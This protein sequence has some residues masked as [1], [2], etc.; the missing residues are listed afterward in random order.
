MA[1]KEFNKMIRLE[2]L[3]MGVKAL[4]YGLPIGTI[5]SFLLCKLL[6]RNVPIQIKFPIIQILVATIGVFIILFI[7]MNYSVKKINKQNTI[8]TLRNENI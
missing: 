3:F 5:I 1:T 8:E 2:S 6:S 4:L 7:I